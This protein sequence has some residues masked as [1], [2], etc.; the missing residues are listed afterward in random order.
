M[1]GVSYG[2][3]SQLFVAATRPPH[4]AAI[5]PLSVI[6]NTATTLY[7]G[8]I[9]NTG[10]ALEWAMDRVHDAEPASP[11]GGQPWAWEQIQNGDATCEANQVLHTA[12]VNLIAKTYANSF[13]RPAVADPLSPVKFVNRIR[14][15]VFLACQFNDEQTGAHCPELVEHFT[16]TRRKWFTFTNGLHIDSLDPAT[17]NRWYDFLSLFVAHKP[18]FLSQ[19]TKDLA[20]A[21]YQV[22]MGVPDITLPSDPIQGK[23]SFPAALRAFTNLKRV[24]ILFDNGDGGDPGEP[25][26][27]FERSFSRFPIPGTRA[28]SLFFSENGLLSRKPSKNAGRDSFTWDKSARGATNFTG[29]TTSGDLWTESPNYQWLPN[30]PGSAVSYVTPTLGRDTAIIGAG[31]VEAFIHSSA[32]DVD[33]QVTVTEVRPD[34]KE[35]YVQSGW[36]RASK[37][38]LDPETSTLL[39]PNPSLRRRDARPLPAKGFAKVTIP[40]YYQGHVYR[41]GS[42]IRVTITAPSGDQP[43]WAFANTVPSGT[44]NVTVAF[45]RRRPSRLILPLVGGVQAPTGLPP[46]PSLRG[47]PCR[48]YQP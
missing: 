40:L 21:I 19:G 47:E 32:R 1:M 5:T 10:F 15:P 12:A 7:P 31:A 43:V 18:P 23:T 3:I 20:P 16:G 14:V 13:Y 45:S 6:D 39:E 11:T 46:C 27:S 34:G 26:A 4:L 33:L 44:A 29:N 24:R 42:R 28:R 30:P 22:A 25:Y 48:T 35:T 36:L 17:F 38:K 41:A 9:L 37:R 2:G 8:G